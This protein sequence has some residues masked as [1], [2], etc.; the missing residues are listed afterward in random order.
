MEPRELWHAGA[1]PRP[2][3]SRQCPRAG[4]PQVPFRETSA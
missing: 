1:N 4:C 3:P 2:H